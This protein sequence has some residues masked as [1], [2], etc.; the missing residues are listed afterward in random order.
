MIKSILKQYWGYDDFRPLQSEIIQ[1]VLEGH[2]TLGMMPTGG[3]KSITFQVPAIALGGLTLVVTPL[4]SL[5]KDQCDHLV[6]RGIKA[7][8]VYMGM[9][10]QEI[11]ETFE[12]VISEDYRFLYISPERLET[13]LFQAK[14]Q[15]MD[16]R[17]LVVDEAHCI[18]QWGYD[19]R[20]PYLKIANLRKLLYTIR[21]QNK[22]PWLPLNYSSLENFSNSFHT[23][24]LALTAT[25]TKEVIE[26]IKNKLHF[27][28]PSRVLK[29]SFERPNLTYSVIYAE[30]KMGNLL[31]MLGGKNEGCSAIVY[32]RSR[33]KT[34]EVATYLTENGIPADYYHAGLR[35]ETKVQRQESWMA[36]TP[37]VI[38]ATNA[39]GMG[40][41]KANVR[42]VI[43]LDLPPSI[44]EYFQEAGRAGR[45]GLPA[46]AV[47]IVSEYDKYK[48]R[49]HLDEE[50]PER[51]YI[52]HVYGRLA[53]F[54]QVAIAAGLYSMFEFD[55]YQ[56]CSA[57]RLSSMQVHYA[58]KLLDQAEYI[59]Y[60]EDPDRHSRLM[61]V[62][63]RESLYH[64]NKFDNEC[65]RIIQALLR[66][67]SGLFADYVYIS[68]DNI[69]KFTGLDRNTLYEKLLLLSRFHVL[70]Y[71]PARQKPAIIYQT[72]RLEDE[73]VK[74]PRT[75]YEE[76][77]ARQEA[78]V[79]AIISYVENSKECRLVQLLN[80][81]DESLDHRCGNCDV[82]LSEKL[83]GNIHEETEMIRQLII[84]KLTAKGPMLV[85]QLV[86]QIEMDPQRVGEVLH[87][88]VENEE[89]NLSHGMLS[90]KG[91]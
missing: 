1:S 87:L 39:F 65:Q 51:E 59:K 34:A 68:E 40:I 42:K 32:M 82:C 63:S 75:I 27:R 15:Y 76:R 62:T 37:S 4:I 45:D 25:A 28:H 57:Y 23:P 5:M 22:K 70:H 48:L 2:D 36:G 17:L 80:Y 54:F 30:D 67:Y 13:R 43:H 44:E 3:G 38:V 35:P 8:A 73:E 11:L 24:C 55:I 20:P 61:F 21:E 86:M 18:S 16:V 26:D 41:D 19:F 12:R 71:I 56:F 29:T 69:M 47:L 91:Y 53:S 58:L 31:R 79:D 52:R 33:K 74:I 90:L 66:L 6:E 84:D 49:K 14:L 88:M 7:A 50:Y 85:Q 46:D 10:Q 9:T 77:R 83:K 81:F 78:R 72:P 89:L 64:L 60:I